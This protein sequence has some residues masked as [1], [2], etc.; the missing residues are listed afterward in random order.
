MRC[1][2]ERGLRP[3]GRVS[4]GGG[5]RL[6]DAADRLLC[7]N[8]PRR[9]DV[10]MIEAWLR[11]EGGRDPWSTVEAGVAT[12]K[13]EEAVARAQLL[14]L[15]V[16]AAWSPE[17]VGPPRGPEVSGGGARSGPVRRVA[18]LS[19]LW[20]GPLC[21]RLLAEAGHPVVKVESEERPDGARFG[22][23]EF[24][25]ALNGGKEERTV[26]AAALASVVAD[27]DVVITSGR[28]RALQG[29]GLDPFE[30]LARRPDLLWVSITGY[31][32]A[33]PW[34]AFGD[35]AAAAGGLVH[36]AGGVF[37]GDALGDP[38]AGLTAAATALELL[39]AGRGGVVDVSMRD[40]ARSLL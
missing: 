27:A 35:D 12:W 20:A 33:S 28:R 6:V 5:A 30:W 23:P 31:G 34:V 26:P 25:R 3:R 36:A 1:A 38:A 19:S 29:L 16:A 21:G 10:E 9:E 13:A 11:C 40:A 37:P 17:E 7:V 4:A 24:F 2:E 14:G 8:L 15:P 22:P 39:A 18:D 32:L